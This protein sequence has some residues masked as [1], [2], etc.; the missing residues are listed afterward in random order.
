M[1]YT[2]FLIFEIGC[3][4]NL[5][6]AHST[7]CP[8]ALPDRYGKLNTSRPLTEDM[9][10]ECAKTAYLELGF[11]GLVGWHYYNEPMLEWERIKILMARIKKGLPLAQFVLWTSG[12]IMPE[13]VSELRIFSQIHLTNY[14]GRDWRFLQR[15]LPDVEIDVFGPHMDDRAVRRKVVGNDRCLRPFNEM[16][17]DYYGNGHLC[18]MDFRGEC[19]LGNVWS[20][21]FQVVAKNF[22]TF[23]ELLCQQ[24]MATIAP[25]VCRTCATGRLRN[26]G[27]L[28]GPIA[29]AAA[30]Y[31]YRKYPNRTYGPTI[32]RIIKT[33]LKKIL[34][35]DQRKA[36]RQIYNICMTILRNT[37]S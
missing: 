27:S 22:I 8:I 6:K 32:K 14:Q 33:Y 2:Q 37:I 20:E 10:I 13:D 17:I 5:A 21:G 28:I 23:Q 36:I 15:E 3:Q 4:C 9:I 31:V 19:V 34:T 26:V 16:I 29:E 18:C 7:L 1:Q 30:E 12:T 25:E 35:P 24:P 11:C